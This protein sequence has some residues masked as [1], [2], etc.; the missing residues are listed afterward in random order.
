MKDNE[1]RQLIDHEFAQ[2]E[3]TD[4]QRLH[5]LRQMKKEARPVMNHK[6][7]LSMALVL[8]LT[9]LTG[10]VAVAT[11]YRG[12]TWFL[13]ER[14]NQTV[15]PAYLM[16]SLEQHHDSQ[17][18]DA[19]VIDAYWDGSN[20]SVACNF[21]PTDPS[22]TLSTYCT[23]EHEH[24]DCS[25]KTADLLLYTTNDVIVTVGSEIIP[26]FHTS[27]NR[28]TE[29]DGSISMMFTFGVNDMTQPLAISISIATLS[30]NTGET[31]QAW[32]HCYLPMMD[33]PIAPHEHDWASATCVSPMTCTICGR[34][35][36]GLGKHDFA[37]ATCIAPKTCRIC[38]V[39]WGTLSLHHQYGDDGYCV[40]CSKY[41]PSADKTK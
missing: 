33:D 27:Y 7:T 21:A 5:T 41:S 6:L 20:L 36:G 1:F 17:R 8:L 12:V 35:T 11:T 32:L 29:E 14:E 34:T 15:N 10:S 39:T 24:H 40:L 19:R 2:L 18:L 25:N 13:T 9:L 37:D 26:I 22:L 4:A 16:D 28:I 30:R 23:L 38:T 31:E 3:W